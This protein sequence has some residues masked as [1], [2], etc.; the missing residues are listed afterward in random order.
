MTEAFVADPFLSVTIGFIVFFVGAF[1]TRKVR[2]LRDFSI[3]EPVSGG[4]FIALL[5]WV[6]REVSGQEIEFDLAVRDYLLVIFFACIGLNARVSDLVVGGKRLA[7][8]L[9]LTIVFMF[10]QNAIGATGALAFGL[11]LEVGVLLGTASLIGGHGT[12]IA[13]GPTIE[14]Q[15]GFAAAAEIGVAAATLGLILAALLGGPI[16]KFLVE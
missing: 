7:I 5:I 10:M 15:T 1:L 4:L 3:P 8:L 11:P 12:A 6:W 13:W 14:A 2:F 9:G 16:A